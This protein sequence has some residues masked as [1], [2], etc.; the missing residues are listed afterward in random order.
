MQ[1]RKY[2]IAR[3]RDGY[4]PKGRG[5]KIGTLT[6]HFDADED[7]VGRYAQW[8]LKRYGAPDMVVTAVHGRIVFYEP[9]GV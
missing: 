2:P 9:R 3:K 6:V 8:W 1:R 5:A 7:T 4:G